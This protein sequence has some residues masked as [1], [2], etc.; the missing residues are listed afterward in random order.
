MWAGQRVH[1]QTLD[2]Q[3]LD[4]QTLDLQSD[5]FGFLAAPAWPLQLE[6]LGLSDSVRPAQFSWGNPGQL[7]S[8]ARFAFA[9]ADQDIEGASDADA[10]APASPDAGH[11]SL[12]GT[13][14]LVALGLALLWGTPLTASLQR[15][16]RRT[17]ASN[18]GGWRAVSRF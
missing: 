16:L 5:G 17:F 12:P 3:T 18:E 11:V 14:V 4:L 1:L 13:L 9:P 6:P 15:W 10:G 8:F 7:S 2:L